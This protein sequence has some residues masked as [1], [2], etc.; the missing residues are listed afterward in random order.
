MAIIIFLII[1]F[2]GSIVSGILGFWAV[3][4][5]LGFSSEIIDVKKIIALMSIY[6]LAWNLSKAILFFKF[7]DWKLSLKVMLVSLP[8]SIFWAYYM[9]VAPIDIIKIV[10]W[11][12]LIIFSLNK[13]FSLIKIKNI[14]NPAI[15]LFS[16]VFWFIDWV[17]WA[18]WPVIWIMLSYMKISKET[19]VAMVAVPTVIISIVKIWIYSSEWFFQKEDATLIISL[20]VIAFLGTYIAKFILKL[21]NPEVFE[22]IVLVLLTIMWIKLLF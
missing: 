3:P 11:I 18:W 9:I 5:V 20:I 7:V 10:L 8:F 14:W 4:I 21:I 22:K 13:L 12:F 2:V 16:S 15:F 17:I 19:F 1:A 6:L